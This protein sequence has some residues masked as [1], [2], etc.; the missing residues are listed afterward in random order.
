MIRW[1]LTVP[2]FLGLSAVLAKVG[3]AT[4]FKGL[5]AALIGANLAV[6]TLAINFASSTYQASDYRQFQRGFAPNLLLAFL[7]VLLWALT[8]AMCL[9][10]NRTHAGIAALSALPTTALL[11]VALVSLAKR[12]AY[13]TALLHQLSRPRR[14]RRALRRYGQALDVRKLEAGEK[15]LARVAR[16]PSHEWGWTTLPPLPAS[17]D[18]FGSLG[19][20][21]ATAAKAGNGVALAGATIH[22]L[23]AL[24]EGHAAMRWKR[25]PAPAEVVRPIQSA[26]ERLARAAEEADST[27]N[28]SERFLN[29]CADYLARKGRGAQQPLAAPCFFVSDLMVTS[30][31]RWL[32]KNQTHP[33]RAPLVTLRQLCQRGV[34][35]SPPGDGK[36]E[37]GSLFWFHNLESLT[38]MMKPLGSAAVK[39]GENAFL[40]LV[41]EAY[42]FLGCDALKAKHDAVV[43]TCVRALAQ[44]GREA[45]AKG[46]ECHWDR[47]ALRPEEHA[48]ERLEWIASWIA[49][50]EPADRSP[51]VDIL[52]QG[53][54]RLDGRVVTDIRFSGHG[55]RVHV[56]PQVSGEPHREGFMANAGARELDYSDFGM[57]KD[58]EL[59]GTMGSWLVQGPLMPFT[60]APV[61]EAAGEQPV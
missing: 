6:A 19:A 42:G 29:T 53:C 17:D 60:A 7:G 25:Q 43:R 8:P 47:C 24:D 61:Q 40:Y 55:G 54:S 15:D 59:H 46:L 51:W 16:M 18:P 27:G 31:G 39:A 44:L 37:M 36:D 26:L 28:L 22:L 2:V 32:A 11:S 56:E 23:A 41:L 35:Q 1:L 14:W 38:G 3:W 4:D 12:E 58:F 45:R 34:E 33:A 49:A 48:R 57:L 10:F 20:V 5:E 30:A 52:R 50:L 9:V 13:P 21:G